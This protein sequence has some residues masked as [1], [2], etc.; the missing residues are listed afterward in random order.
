LRSNVYRIGGGQISEIWIFEGDQ[1]TVDELF[2][3]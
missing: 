1:Y 2:A 3:D